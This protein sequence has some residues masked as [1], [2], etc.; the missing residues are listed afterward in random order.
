M[1][2]SKLKGKNVILA[3][4]SPRRKFFLEELGLDFEIRLKP[5]QEDFP[6]E[7]QGHEISDFLALKKA[8]AFKGELTPDDILVTADTIVWCDQEA[9]NKPEN[10]E[11]ARNMLEKLSGIEHEVISSAAITTTN[12]QIVVTETTRVKFKDLEPG[13]IEYYIEKYQPYDK[14]GSYGIQ[15]WIGFTGIEWIRG[16]YFNVMGF[17]VQKFYETIRKL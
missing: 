14:A 15:E 9:L 16:S 8:E 1:L 10:K 7:L 12:T 6:S 4:G 5:I 3:S 11:E 17:P 13:E 2:N